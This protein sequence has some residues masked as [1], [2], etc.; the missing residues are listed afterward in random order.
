MGAGSRVTLASGAIEDRTKSTNQNRAEANGALSTTRVVSPISFPQVLDQA[1]CIFTVQ[2]LV[3][4][5]MHQYEWACL[6]ELV[7]LLLPRAIALDAYPNTTENHFLAAPKIDSQLH[8]I[9]ILDR[10]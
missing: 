10:V 5:K 7:R 9:A 1:F 8:N 3:V 4:D 6:L 2:L